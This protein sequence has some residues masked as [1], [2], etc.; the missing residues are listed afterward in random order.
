[1][2]KKTLYSL[3]TDLTTPAE[4]IDNMKPFFAASLDRLGVPAF[5][6]NAIA[7]VFGQN[8]T[9]WFR[10]W[11]SKKNPASLATSSAG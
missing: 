6:A 10:L 2:P 1:M 8:E 7:N 3:L 5:A 11:E 9:A 4:L